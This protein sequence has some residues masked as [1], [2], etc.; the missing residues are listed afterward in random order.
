MTKPTVTDGHTAPAALLASDSA[1]SAAAAA[2]IVSCGLR[3]KNIRV[4]R[5]DCFQRN[6]GVWKD[7]LV[8]DKNVTPA[9]LA[10][11]RIDFPAWLQTLGPRQRL[12]AEQLANG[13]AASGVAR[14]FEISRGRVSQLR[15][16]LRDAWAKFHG[17]P[18][19][20]LALATA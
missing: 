14:Q 17:E 9:E 20:N 2:R 1:A 4:E 5:L 7:T 12:I 18:G 15:G 3:K 8:E 13:E 6:E 11:S 10:V 16:A 19:D